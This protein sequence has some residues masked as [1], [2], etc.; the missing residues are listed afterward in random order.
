MADS[1]IDTNVLLVASAADDESPFSDT[2]RTPAE[3]Q[4][5]L[6]WLVDFSSGNNLLILD[7]YNLIYDEY[8]RNLH[9]NDIGMRIV[10]DKMRR[11]QLRV[12]ILECEPDGTALVPEAFAALDR[13]DR[14]FL[15]LALADRA[16]GHECEIINATDTDD[17]RAIESVCAEHG[18]SIFHLLDD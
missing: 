9:A 11:W 10:V 3:C 16:A 8:V 1:I 12:H 18:I 2:H 4:I 15:A 6:Q 13:S 17:W 7:Q 14:K 5:V